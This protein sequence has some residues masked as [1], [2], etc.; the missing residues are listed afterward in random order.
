MSPSRLIDL[1]QCHR[2]T[3]M[4]V[5]RLPKG[6]ANVLLPF[7]YAPNDNAPASGRYELLNI[8]G[9]PTHEAISA[10]EGERL[11][12]APL[13]YSWRLVANDVEVARRRVL[14]AEER[15]ARQ[16]TLVQQR[17]RPWAGQYWRP[18]AHRLNCGNTICGRLKSG[19][20][21][22]PRSAAWTNGID[23]RMS[24]SCSCHLR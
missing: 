21:I 24:V 2:P 13:G 23:A 7:E 18:C 22:S 16:E 5:L 8:S 3:G 14:E 12:A 19:Q 15:I 20:K 1:G 6:R 11:P 4:E 10:S 9:T 17:R